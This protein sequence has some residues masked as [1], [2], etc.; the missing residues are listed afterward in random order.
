M[1]VRGVFESTYDVQDL[2]AGVEPP[3]GE[4]FVPRRELVR[5]STYI[6][7]MRIEGGTAGS[8]EDEEGS[9]R[10]CAAQDCGN[11]NDRTS[12]HVSG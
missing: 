11:R 8:C 5:I 3:H 6:G 9:K 10:A 7:A 2:L 4:R 1:H 12:W